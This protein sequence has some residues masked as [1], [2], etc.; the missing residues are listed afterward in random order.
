[1][2]ALP[3]S[4]VLRMA[5]EVLERDQKLGMLSP[6]LISLPTAAMHIS[7]QRYSQNDAQIGWLWTDF[8]VERGFVTR[9]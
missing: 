7:N 4:L 2:L 3:I 6:L 5:L 8:E 1:M 9:G